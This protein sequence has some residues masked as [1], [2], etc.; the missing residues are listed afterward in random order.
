GFEI[1]IKDAQSDGPYHQVIN[2]TWEGRLAVDASM[3]IAPPKSYSLRHKYGHRVRLRLA[4]DDMPSLTM[5]LGPFGDIVNFGDRGFY[6]SWY[7]RGMTFMTASEGVDPNWHQIDR[8]ERLANFRSSQEVWQELCPMLRKLDF[9]EDD[10][11][12][13]SGLI[14]ALGDTDIDDHD[15]K[16]HTRHEVGVSSVDGYHTVNTGKFTLFPLMA[17]TVV[18]RVTKTV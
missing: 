16:L 2:A 12:P 1:G 4:P 10:I 15:S 6:L 9:V 14:Y 8:Q 17:M 18:E 13:T 11:D 5:V 3:G 7:P